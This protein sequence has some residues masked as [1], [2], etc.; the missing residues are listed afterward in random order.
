MFLSAA[1]SFI[2]LDKPWWRATCPISARGG[3]DRDRSS[4][5]GINICLNFI[6]SATTSLAC[7]KSMVLAKLL[8][9]HPFSHA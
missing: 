8:L 5:Y 2:D 7:Q 1:F 3:M 6:F 4:Q 9:A